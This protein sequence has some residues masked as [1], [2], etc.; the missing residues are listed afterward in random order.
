MTQ[1]YGLA[2]A[3]APAALALLAACSGIDAAT[4]PRALRSRAPLAHHPIV[5]VHGW[6]A[7]ASTWATMVA[8]FKADGW[9]DA[10]LATWSYK[11]SQPNA[12]TA[13]QIKVKVDSILAA[14]GAA[15]VDIISHSMGAL[16]ARYYVKNL[17]GGAK[18]DAWIALG[19][20]NYGTSTAYACTSTPCREMW[21]SSDFLDALNAG[22]DVPGAPRY[23]TWRSPC[24]E[25]IIP[26]RNAQL[27]GAKNTE[28]GCI[29]HSQLH[30]SAAVYAQVRSWAH[31]GMVIL[32]SRTSERAELALDRAQ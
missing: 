3:L 27:I 8:R 11:T 19:G 23:A 6:N 14:T 18:V 30:E 31:A 16:S 22:T 2:R 20:T 10:E 24:D 13:Q 9:T 26:Q 32:A 17:G 21:P 12:T 28:T 4:G 29:K 7:N 25:V 5:F 15:Q 1:R